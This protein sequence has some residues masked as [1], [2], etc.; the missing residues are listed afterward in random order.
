MLTRGS[1]AEK[2]DRRFTIRGVSG[3]GMME[4]VLMRNAEDEIKNHK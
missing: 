4:H 3:A 1:L 2:R